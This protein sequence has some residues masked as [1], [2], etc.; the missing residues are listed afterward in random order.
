MS[1]PDPLAL[2]EQQV[3]ERPAH[4][5]VAT[6][7]TVVTYG[8]LGALASRI[9]AAIARSPAPHPRVLILLPQGAGAVAAMFGTLMAGGYYCPVNVSAPALRVER[10][11]ALFEPDV[12]VG[13]AAT[14]GVLAG[15]KRPA[16]FV[17][18]TRLDGDAWP[19]NRTPHDLAYVIFTSGSTGDPKGVMIPRTALAN[20]VEWVRDAM[21]VTPADRWSQHPNIGFDLSVLD[22]Y[23]AVCWGATLY[24]LVNER[25][26]LLP[27]RFITRH[28][29]TIWDSVPSVLDLMAEDP[30][31]RTGSV[32]SV[33]LWTF[34][35]EPLYRRQV[36]AIFSVSP[37]CTVHNTY[38][39]TE[40]T[41]SCTLVRLT[42]D[43]YS[44]YCADTVCLGAAIA[45]MRVDLIDGS[46]EEGEVVLSGVQ[47][48]RGYWGRPD[49]TS[50]AF[51]TVDIDG[52][53][54]RIYRTGDWAV[55]RD[56]QLY[57][58]GRVD[59]QVKI[60]GYRVELESIDAAVREVSG[61]VS[62]TLL[63]DRELHCFIEGNERLDRDALRTALQQRLMAH[64]VPTYF[65]AAVRLPRS[66]NDKIDRR[67]VLQGFAAGTLG[68]RGAV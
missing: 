67:G 28:Q 6:G 66:V 33:R 37:H 64:E 5:A 17:D 47:L 18:V 35:G 8:E 31:W 24:P 11:A 27:V 29:L 1:C 62:C 45:N 60:R 48:A 9:A 30:H 54:R 14:A 68:D 57:F 61:R 44:R 25:D 4:P 50:R 36:E 20:Y 42:P 49:L 56:G 34:C 46:A 59:N 32:D 7:A 16:P 53:A 2:F 23:G 19:G 38:G 39:P 65:Y 51:Q 52:E 13:T 3:R 43:N 15:A 58:A 26:R 63:H 22:V 40:A 41:V 10:I 12:V 21:E 55:A